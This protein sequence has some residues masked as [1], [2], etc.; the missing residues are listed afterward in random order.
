[1]DQFG[2]QIGN[3]ASLSFR[4][5]KLKS[6]VLPFDVPE[7]AQPLPKYS[8][9]LFRIGI[10]NDQR[11]DRRHLRM[12]RSRGKRAC[13]RYTAKQRDDLASFPLMEM[14]PIPH[15]PERTGRISEVV[16]AR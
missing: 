9:K 15:G 12:L 14:H 7:I 3:S 10:A 4:R 6:N 13:D 5:S 8:P 2:G 1:M 16:P 11:A